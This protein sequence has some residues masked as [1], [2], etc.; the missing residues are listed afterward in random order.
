MVPVSPWLWPMTSV[1]I[2]GSRDGCHPRPKK[3]RS[4]RGFWVAAAIPP[5]GLR[6]HSGI[7]ATV[8]L[9]TGPGALFC[10]AVQRLVR[11]KLSPIAVDLQDPAD[12]SQTRYLRGQLLDLGMELVGHF[13][14]RHELQT[15][16]EKSALRHS[17]DLRR[18]GA[19]GV[20]AGSHGGKS[21]GVRRTMWQSP[22]SH[23]HVS[24]IK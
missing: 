16:L 17:L 22:C 7:A 2:A 1:R 14:E 6:P 5:F 24:E 4:Q 9:R 20:A 23:M 10:R 8:A 13:I 19:E 18:L 21:P 11:Q 3:Q 15:I 12:I